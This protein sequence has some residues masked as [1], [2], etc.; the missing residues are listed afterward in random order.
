MTMRHEVF[1]E[2]ANVLHAPDTEQGVQFWEKAILPPSAV[3][4]YC[5]Q[6]NA[7]MFVY[8]LIALGFCLG[9]D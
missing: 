5:S 1:N 3:P 6:N 8:D 7:V 4:F 2:T 9:V